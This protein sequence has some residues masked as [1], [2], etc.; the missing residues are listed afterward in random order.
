M[1]GVVL[2]L[3][4]SSTG[5]VPKQPVE[6]LEVSKAGCIGDQQNDQRHHGGPLRAVC[7]LEDWVLERLQRDGHPI[8]PGSTG[9]NMLISGCLPGDLGIG[10]QLLVGPVRLSI[11]SA[12]V[13]C[14]TIRN[15]FI[16]GQFH[17]LNNKRNPGQTRWYAEVIHPGTVRLGDEVR[18]L[19]TSEPTGNP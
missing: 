7:L 5:G 1:S 16:D 10:S 8:F 14:K 11:T 4:A 9:E 19:T 15:S 12:A 3:H 6:T 2:G 18:L 17:H 13:P